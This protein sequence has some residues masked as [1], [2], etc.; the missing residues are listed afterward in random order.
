MCT[1]ARG[2]VQARVRGVWSRELDMATIGIGAACSCG[3]TDSWD[4]SVQVNV[5]YINDVM[6]FCK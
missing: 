1:G 2:E 6:S 5:F 4:K 3:L